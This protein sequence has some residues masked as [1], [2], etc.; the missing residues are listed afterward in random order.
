MDTGWIED[1]LK[2]AEEG[3]FSRAAEAR[4]LSQPA[5]SRR[6]KGLEEWVGTVL[7]D[8]DT[9]RIA[10]T[11]AG[12]AFRAVAEEVL[13]RLALG[14][15]EARE[16]GTTQANTLRFAATHALSTTFFPDW[17]RTF[18]DQE[19]VGTISLIADNMQACER[20]M[21]EGRVDLLLCHHHPAASHKLDQSGFRSMAL[22]EDILIPVCVPDAQ[23]RPRFPLPGSDREP[24]PFL[25]FDERSGMG[26]IL[27]ASEVITRSDASLRPVFRSHLASALLRMARDGK[28]VAWAP[29]SLCAPDLAAGRLVRAG[30]EQWSVPL[31][32]R[33]FRPR[34][35]RSAVVEAFWNRLPAAAP[36]AET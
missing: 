19:D 12:V 36:L 10:L 18:E 9:H 6:I 11:E 1:F 26:R 8:R 31:E 24:L 33:L 32:I 30:G 21:L 34:A 27:A 23:N 25:E 20:L 4:N 22:G 7:I 14:R 28:G 3:N 5:F 17:L 35:R 2:L 15:D 16:I 29:L 13:R